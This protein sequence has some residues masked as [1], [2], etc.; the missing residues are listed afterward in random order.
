MMEQ[1]NHSGLMYGLG[2]YL[3][4]GSLPIYWKFLDHVSAF[5]ILANRFIWSA[6]FVIF[7]LYVLKK[8]SIFLQETKELFSSWKSGLTMFI[9]ALT[10]CCNWG[11]Y[12]WSV[13]SG[14]IV[15]ASMGYYI[16]PLVSIL[17]GL[18][19]LKERMDRLQQ[20][21]VG[22]AAVGIA[23]M[24]IQNGSLPWV[25]VTLAVSFAFYGLLKKV[26]KV[27][28]LTSIL[29]E[30]LFMTP[31]ALGY[32]YY[33]SQ[34]GGNSYQN[35]DLYTQ[36]LLIGAGVVTA[37]PLLLFTRSAQLLPLNILGFIQY[38]SPTITLLLGV[39]VY[40]EAFDA[41]HLYA[42]SCIWLGLLFFTWSQIRAR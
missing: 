34:H 7:L 24:I 40:G 17:F 20:V 22:C 11:T 30:T 25:S 16:N 19:F 42:F 3:L 31:V 6:I 28:A 5:E 33:L 9:A 41:T 37:V 29:L 8:R 12:I 2:A 23:I 39:F 1:R 21:A 15:E 36:L 13:T 14:R 26:I 35:S 18:I 4:W 27:Q 32:L 38:L 10:I